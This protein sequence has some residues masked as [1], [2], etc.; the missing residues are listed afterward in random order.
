MWTSK[1]K[2]DEIKQGVRGYL[3]LFGVFMIDQYNSVL[4]LSGKYTPVLTVSYLIGKGSHTVVH[5]TVVD[6]F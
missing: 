1:R 6:R 4:D 5:T 3:Q 2:R